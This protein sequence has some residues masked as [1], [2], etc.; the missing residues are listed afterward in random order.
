LRRSASGSC[1]VGA[2]ITNLGVNRRAL[3]RGTGPGSVVVLAL[4][5]QDAQRAG[6]EAQLNPVAF[7]VTRFDLVAAIVDLDTAYCQAALLHQRIDRCYRLPICHRD[8]A[9]MLRGQR[10]RAHARG[11]NQGQG[12]TTKTKKTRHEGLRFRSVVADVAHEA[13]AN[14][15]RGARRVQ[16]A[17]SLAHDNL[18][19]PLGELNA[20]FANRR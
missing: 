11:K 19:W 4:W 10:S 17:V 8:A 9:I 18:C 3:P 16:L 15:K 12:K 20:H 2:S 13:D 5:L 14:L 1:Q 6:I 7:C